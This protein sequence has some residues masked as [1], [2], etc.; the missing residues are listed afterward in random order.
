MKILITGASGSLGGHIYRLASQDN[1][2]NVTG[3]K[4]HA[5]EE[6]PDLLT[7]DLSDKK[8]ITE[9]C[10]SR[11]FDAVIHTAAIA[12]VEQCRLN[13]ELAR[14]VNRDGTKYLLQKLKKSN[15]QIRSLYVSTDMVFHGEEAPFDEFKEINPLSEY[16]RSKVAGEEVF[17][18][19]GGDV[20]VRLPLMFGFSA[21]GRRTFFDEQV[22]RI[23]SNEE[24]RLFND[25]WRTPISYRYAAIALLDILKSSFK[26]LIH[27][28]GENRVS[29]FEFGRLIGALLGSAGE[30]ITQVS[31]RDVK[32]AEPRARD[33]SLDIS[34]WGRE[35]PRHLEVGLEESLKEEFLVNP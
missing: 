27:V 16:G 28:A 9:F 18:S 20:I 32:L 31:V 19:I 17:S 25:E 7:L 10:Q 3:V 30:N 4:S 23:Q 21:N 35:F 26:G 22:E 2:L 5:S 29:R 33:L 8:Q 15:S 34:L 13:P 24:L 6:C 12:S 1:E 11:S 14:A